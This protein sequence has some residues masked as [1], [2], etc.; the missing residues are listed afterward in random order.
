MNTSL[1]EEKRFGSIEEEIEK[2]FQ[3]QHDIVSYQG[4]KAD[5]NYV[6]LVKMRKHL[7]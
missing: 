5:V 7:K 6:V 2:Q 3:A 4:L 1:G